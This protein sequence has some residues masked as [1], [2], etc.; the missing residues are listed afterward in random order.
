LGEFDQ[1]LLLW[2]GLLHDIDKKGF[3]EIGMK[4]VMH[5]FRSAGMALRMMGGYGWL[6]STE[7]IDMVETL[8]LAAQ[9]QHPTLFIPA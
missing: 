3:N 9:K 7:S 5:P 8:L 1:N 2:V 4:D 6:Q